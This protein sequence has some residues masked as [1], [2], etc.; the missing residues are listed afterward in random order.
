MQDLWLEHERRVLGRRV[1]AVTL[2]IL[3]RSD[4]RQERADY[5]TA[6]FAVWAIYPSLYRARSETLS[7]SRCITV[8]YDAAN[9][10]IG[11]QSSKPWTVEL[12]HHFYTKT[13]AT[14]GWGG[15]RSVTPKLR[16]SMRSM[17]REC[18]TR[19]EACEL[20]E[21]LVAAIQRVLTTR[22]AAEGYG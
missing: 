1:V 3:D 15:T 6:G 17:E 14:K 21:R 22:L 5:R 18:R 8:V 16:Y 7:E 13:L 11:G 10:R 2:D 19:A 12:K 9:C 20:V 4:P